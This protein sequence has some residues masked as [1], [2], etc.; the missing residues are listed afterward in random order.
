[1]VV[2]QVLNR[3]NSNKKSVYNKEI[4]INNDFESK[5]D[6]LNKK[7]K[8]ALTGRIARNFAHEIRNPLTNINLAIEQ[9]KQELNENNELVTTYIDILQ[10]NSSRINQLVSELIN[11]CKPTELKKELVSIVSILNESIEEINH[12]LK[13]K[14]IEI[15]KDFEDASQVFVDRSKLKL[16]FFNIILNS[17]EAIKNNKGKINLELFSHS[18]RYIVKIRDNGS[19][20]A[21]E[22]LTKIFDPFY[23]T[24]SNSRGLGLNFAQNIIMAHKGQID[25]SSANNKG[26][27]VIITIPFQ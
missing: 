18:N 24:K 23:S 26:T 27:A 8:L 10:R 12:H 6:Y 19:G 17:I 22:E 1:M 7:G 21:S 5:K 14:K 20:I 13:T 15:I 3:V 16:V 4:I 9:I 25:V 11:L 2:N